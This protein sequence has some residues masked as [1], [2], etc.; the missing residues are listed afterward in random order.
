M[1]RKSLDKSKI[2]VV[3]LEGI[4]SSAVEALRADGYSDIDYYPKALPE[5]EL[6]AAVK[7]A[8]LL[9]IRSNTQLTA[10]VLAAAPKLIAAGCFCIGTNQVDLDAAEAR[11]IPRRTVLAWLLPVATG[12][13]GA[14]GAV[15]VR[16]RRLRL[17]VEKRRRA[18]DALTNHGEPT[19][20]SR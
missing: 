19:E 8:Y 7:D 10:R 6:I 2:K 1:T 4:H 16:N 13:A 3:L 9:G 11:G 5:D 17:E 18:N 20:R 12:L 14:M 15:V